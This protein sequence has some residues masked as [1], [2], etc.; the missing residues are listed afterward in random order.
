VKAKILRALGAVASEA[1]AWWLFSGLV[2]WAV[3][4]LVVTR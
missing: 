4:L 1:G 2:A 3:V